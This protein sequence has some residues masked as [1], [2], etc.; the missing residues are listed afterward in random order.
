MFTIKQFWRN[1]AIPRHRIHA[2]RNHI[3]AEL[4]EFTPYEGGEFA[5]V[6]TLGKQPGAWDTHT[7][8]RS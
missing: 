8:V 7:P 6:N 3:T 5:H 2:H 1:V 4:G